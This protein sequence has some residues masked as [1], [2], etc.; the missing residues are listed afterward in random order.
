MG[1]GIVPAHRRQ[2]RAEESSV[3][4]IM[5]AVFLSQSGPDAK[6]A[7]EK[8]AAF[9]PRGGRKAALRLRKGRRSQKLNRMPIREGEGSVWTLSTSEK[10][11]LPK[12]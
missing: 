7:A 2:A 11:I 12:S 6:K 1:S 10:P 8:K 4:N 9:L 5:D 3:S